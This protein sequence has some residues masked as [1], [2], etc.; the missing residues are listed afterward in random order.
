MLCCHRTTA[1]SSLAAC[2]FWACLLPQELSFAAVARLLGLQTSQ[3]QVLA[4]TTI[5][6]IVRTHGQFI[7]QAEQAG[8]AALHRRDDL[9]AAALLVI[10]HNQPRRRAGWP[11]ELNAAVDTAL[12][13]QQ[14]CPPDGVSWADWDRVLAARRA[15]NTL[16]LEDL[17]HLGPELEAEQVLVTVDEVLTRKPEPHHFWEP[18]TARGHGGWLPL[19][20]WHG[21]QSPPA[22]GS[23]SLWMI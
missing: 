21:C 19:S 16:A 4:D 6:T 14:V 12:A 17:R 5:R 7:R 18:R 23:S 13:A 11:E 20:E 10:P 8:V 9:T 15:E 22:S 3:A 2:I 1:S